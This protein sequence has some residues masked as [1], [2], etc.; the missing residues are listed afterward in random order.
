MYSVQTRAPPLTR[1]TPSPAIFD[2]ETALVGVGVGGRL[3]RPVGRDASAPLPVSLTNPT[4]SPVVAR[5]IECRTRGGKLH[6]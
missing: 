4:L 2:M 3:A 1:A 6:A 5:F